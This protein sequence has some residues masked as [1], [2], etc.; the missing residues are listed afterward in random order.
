MTT[1]IVLALAGII[2]ISAEIIAP[3][4]ILGIAGAICLMVSFAM[5][6]GE[7]GLHGASFFAVGTCIMTVIIV[8]VE[9]KLLKKTRLGRSFFLS[10]VSGGAAGTPSNPDALTEALVGESAEA[11]S[12]L[13]P[14]GLVLVKGKQYQAVCEDGLVN[15]GQDLKVV[16][17]D[18]FRLIVRKV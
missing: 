10:S 12:T 5:A 15:K 17:Q 14:M 18:K 16:Q 13:A 9:F 6:Y 8:F 4:G 3:G 7:F 11:L 2:L 1:I